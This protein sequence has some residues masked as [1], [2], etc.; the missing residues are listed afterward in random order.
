MNLE[1]GHELG[2]GYNWDGIGLEVLRIPG[3]EV[4]R[5]CGVRTEHL[6]GILEVR[7][8]QSQATQNRVLIQG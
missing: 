3:N 8:T 1:D 6:E 2:G 5:F 7:P 4:V